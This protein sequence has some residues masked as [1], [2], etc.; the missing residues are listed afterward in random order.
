MRWDASCSGVQGSCACEKTKMLLLPLL[1]LLL[2]RGM[3]TATEGVE[4]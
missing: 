2:L 4:W 3:M 1:L